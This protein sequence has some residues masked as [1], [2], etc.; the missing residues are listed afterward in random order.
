MAYRLSREITDTSNDSGIE[1]NNVYHNI[2][3]AKRLKCD[4]R[5]LRY[6]TDRKVS[7]INVH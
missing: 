7:V 6:G 5:I 4:I 1:E 2:V 3:I